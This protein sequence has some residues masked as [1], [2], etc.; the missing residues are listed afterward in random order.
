MA[1]IPLLA[2]MS[3]KAAFVNSLFSGSVRDGTQNGILPAMQAGDLYFPYADSTSMGIMLNAWLA[4]FQCNANAVYSASAYAQCPAT[5]DL[6]I[7]MLVGYISDNQLTYCR[8]QLSLNSLQEGTGLPIY[9]NPGYVRLAFTSDGS[10]NFGSF[11]AAGN[12]NSSGP[13]TVAL[14]LRDLLFG[15]HIVAV[16]SSKDRNGGNT[17][18]GLKATLEA[19]LPTQTD[20]Y[21]SHYTQSINGVASGDYYAPIG[22]PLPTNLISNV[23]TMASSSPPGAEPLLFSALVG[24]TSSG[25]T[26]PNNFLQVEGWPAQNWLTPVGGT[27]HNADYQTN[28][29]TYWN[30][31]TYGAC[32][33]SEK[34]STPLFLANSDFDLTCHADTGMPYY[35]GA[36]QGNVGDSW[37][38]PDLIVLS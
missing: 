34:R 6:F 35:Y 21:N 29:S 12:I 13:S 23:E 22:A 8:P 11:D 30:I 7:K 28:N 37:M 24:N 31:S 15:A 33:Y 3:N 9:N 17:V 10:W 32:A 26:S 14:F 2:N 16:C 38:H 27:R 4:S 19:Q 18:S 20:L 1:V 5:D 36:N 25:M